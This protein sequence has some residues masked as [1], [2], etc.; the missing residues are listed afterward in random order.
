MITVDTVVFDVGETIV[1]DS[2]EFA[3]WAR[4]LGVP[5]HTFS[6]VFGAGRAYGRDDADIF[7]YFRRA[8]DL[9]HERGLRAEAGVGER[10]EE[11]DLYPD[12]RPALSAL[13]A[14]GVKVGIAGNQTAVAAD[15]LRGLDLPADAIA[16]SGQ[17][18]VRKPDRAFFARVVDMCGG[19]DPAT[20]LYVGDRPDRDVYP[21]RKAGL[22]TALIRRGV[23]GYLAATDPRL[24]EAADLTIS[25]LTELADQI[26]PT[27]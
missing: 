24:R 5:A 2:R 20:T 23:Q 14:R 6:A 7:G 16:T 25:S 19:G 21:A 22:H 9:D 12:A 15:L 1:D 13:R 3:A 18:G 4:W 11:C 27:S 10:I 17:W 8:I 26:T